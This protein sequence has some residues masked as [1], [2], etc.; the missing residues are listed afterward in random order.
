M[1]IFLSFLFNAPIIK[2]TIDF[3]L[4]ELIA[5]LNEGYIQTAD[6]RNNHA[7][8]IIFVEKM[9]HAGSLGE[10]ILIVSDKGEKSMVKKTGFGYEF[11][12]V[13]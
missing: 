2:L 1:N 7:D 12:V 5:K 9:L 6:D 3:S 11:K 13:K 10:N 4:Y 8:F